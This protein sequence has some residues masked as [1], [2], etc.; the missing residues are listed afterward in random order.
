MT[1]LPS[2]CNLCH[3]VL[4]SMHSVQRIKHLILAKQCSNFCILFIIIIILHLQLGQESVIFVAR[5]QEGCPGKSLVFLSGDPA[6][7]LQLLGGAALGVKLSVHLVATS[8]RR[9]SVTG[10]GVFQREI[11]VA[12]G[13]GQAGTDDQRDDHAKSPAWVLQSGLRGLKTR[14]G[15]A[16]QR[17]QMR[18]GAT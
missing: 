15:T 3:G 11:D 12:D 16:C 8:V 4:P 7:R 13:N 14:G 5:R 6:R 1:K 2:L 17:D 18:A 10:F 9:A